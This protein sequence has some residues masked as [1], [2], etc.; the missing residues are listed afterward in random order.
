MMSEYVQIMT[1]TDTKEMAKRIAETLVEKKLAACVQ[2]SGPINST[3][4]WKGNIENEDE[5]YCMIKTRKSLYKQVEESI[6]T[7]H[8]YDVP[9]IIA[10]PILEGNQAYFDW[11]DAV[12]ISKSD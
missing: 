12:V 7:I 8:S 11:I 10:L 4:E 3:Y 9:E 1:T 5:W 2:V 6:K